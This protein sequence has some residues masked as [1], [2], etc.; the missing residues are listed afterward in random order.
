MP[1]LGSGGESNHP[2]KSQVA[3]GVAV[4][5]GDRGDRT[6][7][8]WRHLDWAGTGLCEKLLGCGQI[9]HTGKNMVFFLGAELQLLK[10]VHDPRK[11]PLSAF[12]DARRPAGRTGSLTG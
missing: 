4:G 5:S 12:G 11:L 1:G 10:D 6:E 3:S 2:G 7:S 9:L 8:W